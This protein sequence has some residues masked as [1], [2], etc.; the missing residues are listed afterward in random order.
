MS[1]LLRQTTAKQDPSGGGEGGRARCSVVCVLYE[2]LKSR[3]A[4][5]F[6]NPPPFLTVLCARRGGSSHLLLL[7]LVREPRNKLSGKKNV[8]DISGKGRKDVGRK[9]TVRR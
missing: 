1:F 5:G 8:S 2:S 3:A 9:G 4:N 7:L 6:P